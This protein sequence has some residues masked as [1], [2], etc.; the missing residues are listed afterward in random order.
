MAAIDKIYVDSYEKYVEFKKWCEK[1]PLFTDKYNVKEPMTR[2]LITGWEKENWVEH[3]I[4]S[5]PFYIDA[6]IIRNC[7]FDYIQKELMLW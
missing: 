4:A 6:Y 7:P 2:Y 3:P 1:Q 5:F